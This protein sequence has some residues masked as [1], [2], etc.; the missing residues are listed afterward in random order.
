MKG[1]QPEQPGKTYGQFSPAVNSRSTSLAAARIFGTRMTSIY[2]H[3]TPFASLVYLTVIPN[4][5][6]PPAVPRNVPIPRSSDSRRRLGGVY[7]E[8]VR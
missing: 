5:R 8:Q 3:F 7:D 4:P 6:G 1:N 2:S